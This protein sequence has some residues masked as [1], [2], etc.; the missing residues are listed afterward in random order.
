MAP[1]A[2]RRVRSRPI[3]PY[4]LPLRARTGRKLAG[5]GKDKAGRPLDVAGLGYCAYDLLCLADVDEM[6]DFDS[7]SGIHLA[8]M[9]HDGGGPVGTALTAL[10][11]LGARAGY[12]GVLG[13]DREGRTLQDLFARVGVDVS[14]LRVDPRAGTNVCA[15][16]VQQG[17]GQR[18]IFCHP[19]VQPQALALDEV[20]RAY[21]Q[22]ARVLHLDGQFL[23]AAIVAAGWAR[24][25]GVK[26]CFDG[27]HP[28]PGLE[29]LLPLVDW[30]VVA[31]PFPAAY[32]GSASREEAARTL[33]Q[34]GPE[35][36]VVTLGERGCQVWVRSR[37]PGGDDTI[38]HLTVP[39]FSVEVVDTT[40]AGDAFHGA[41]I[42]GMLQG[43]ALGRVAEFANAVAALN[44]QTLGGRRGL[45]DLAQVE[46]FLAAAG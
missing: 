25:A 18:A 24:E 4:Q 46:A 38:E 8:D 20:D 12:L 23:P 6:P 45:P 34:L 10:A 35:L 27:N 3:P 32:T 13:E 44:C 1:L 31:E 15:I 14:R 41:F 9:V 26:V 19:R 28:R 36:L 16:L 2:R 7:V 39:G 22:S 21:V 5:E 42:Y 17:T 43:W 29:A 30:L 11:R 40:G 33:L 37:D